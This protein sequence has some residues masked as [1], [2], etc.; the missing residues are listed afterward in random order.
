M[1]SVAQQGL[2]MDLGEVDSTQ[3]E[4][5]RQ[6][7]YHRL[8]N[9]TLMG[10]FFSEKISFP[11]FNFAQEY[12]NHYSLNLQSIPFYSDNFI[13]LGPGMFGSFSP[14]Q[15]NGTVLSQAAY[16]L[17]DKFVLGGFSYGANSI[18]SAPFLN[19]RGTYFDSY[20]STMFMQYKVSKNF[21][22][23]T[24]VSVGQHNGMGPGF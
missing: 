2:Q 19:Q 6:M 14:F 17:G 10:N 22:I 12:Q 7:D 16:K 3:L 15:R 24:R 5:Q 8:I 4:L 20:G 13:G 11:D 23:E 1:N 21:K 18:H 9:G